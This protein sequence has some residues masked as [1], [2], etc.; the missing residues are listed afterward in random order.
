MN[1]FGPRLRVYRSRCV[2]PRTGKPLTQERLGGLLRE[3]MGVGVSG[4]AVSDWERGESKIHADDR[5][6]LVSLVKI[7]SENGGIHSLA[8]ANELLEAGNY[9]GLNSAEIQQVF[10]GRP[11]GLNDSPLP[12]GGPGTFANIREEWGNL[13]DKARE[14]PSPAWPRMVTG[15]M[16]GLSDKLSAFGVLRALV[17]LWL[18]LF[19]HALVA[20]SL[21]WPFT[22]RESLLRAV[23]LF[24]AG[25][26]TLPAFIGLSVK[27]KDSKFWRETQLSNSPILRLYTHQGAFVGFHV[28]YFLVFLFFSILNFLRQSSALW[29][30]WALMLV[31]LIMGY[32]GAREVPYSLWRAY[33]RLRLRDGGVFFTFI[34]VGPF[35]SFFLAQ[36]FS[37]LTSSSGLFFVLLAIT[38]LAIGMA[39]Q[40]RKNARNFS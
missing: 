6:L 40:A 34:L 21:R 36:Y 39:W 35:W 12:H 11:A 3:E 7:L 20:P 33:G 14:G 17:F 23:A 19:T 18:W 32:V 15:L 5:L 37:L 31:P 8:D 1:G 29:F 24:C 22:D 30:E 25:T 4:A 16:R 28:G 26:L 38:L 13:L 2:D 27:T 9:R 10:A